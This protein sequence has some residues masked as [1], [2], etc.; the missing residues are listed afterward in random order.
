V[1]AKII[2]YLTALVPA[3]AIGLLP[4]VSLALSGVSLISGGSV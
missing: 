1:K 3:A 2:K 4:L